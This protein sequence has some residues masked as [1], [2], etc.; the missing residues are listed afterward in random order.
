MSE[1]TMN[2]LRAEGMSP[3]QLSAEISRID[4]A[5][6]K[7]ARPREVARY[8]KKRAILFAELGRRRFVPCGVCGRPVPDKYEGKRYACLACSVGSTKGT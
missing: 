1:D 7:A 4:H 3:E 6:T 5:I 2:R 8:Q